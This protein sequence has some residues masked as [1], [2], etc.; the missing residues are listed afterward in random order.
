MSETV[1]AIY[2]PRPGQEEALLALVREHVPVLRERGLVTDF[3]PIVL[4]AP[5]GALLEIFEWRS[6]EAVEA[7]HDDPA[8]GA[9]WKRFDELSTFGTLGKLPGAGGPFPHFERVE[10]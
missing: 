7:A 9:L 2:V 6:K 5:D 3:E 8:V 10:L 4:R 1:I